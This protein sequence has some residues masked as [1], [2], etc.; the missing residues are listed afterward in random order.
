[1]SLVWMQNGTVGAQIYFSGFSL[2]YHYIALENTKKSR[3]TT[4]AH[5]PFAIPGLACSR[6]CDQAVHVSRI[7]S[8]ANFGRETSQFVSPTPPNPG[9][10]WIIGLTAC[11]WEEIFEV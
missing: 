9:V 6:F 2:T 5:P 1:M 3:K 10:E 8:V 7:R 4:C 11:S